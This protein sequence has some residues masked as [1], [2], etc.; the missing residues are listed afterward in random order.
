MIE[1]DQ[2]E[3]LNKETIKE[4]L[5]I[6]LTKLSKFTNKDITKKQINQLSRYIDTNKTIDVNLIWKYFDTL[7]IDYIEQTIDRKIKIKLINEFKLDKDIDIDNILWNDKFIE[8]Y[9]MYQWAKI[10]KEIFKKI[11]FDFINKIDSTDTEKNKEWKENIKQKWVDIEFFL[12]ENKKIYDI[13]PNDEKVD[14]TKDIKHFVNIANN[15]LK[16]L[17]IEEEFDNEWKLISYFDENIKKNKDEILKTSKL[18]NWEFDTIFSDLSFQV[19]SIKEI[20]ISKKAKEITSISIYKEKEPIKI[21]MM[22]NNVD[23]SCLSFYSSVWNYWATATNA[24]DINKWVFYFE[25]QKGD[26]IARVLT[27]IDDEGNLLRFRIY[28][29]WNIEIDLDEYFDDYIKEIAKKSWLWFN[30]DIKKV[31]LL[32]WEGWY[33][34]PVVE[35]Y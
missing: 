25:D 21:L 11:L 16:L 34:D 15:K 20:L 12:Q 10:N 6:M 33:K 27:A 19:K 17:W 14:K 3:W 8:S 23:G 28:K 30:G 29:K 5:S 18:S 9:K 1:V 26:I 22:W 4:K 31:S 32:N 24:L 35:I 7:I 13:S 2:L